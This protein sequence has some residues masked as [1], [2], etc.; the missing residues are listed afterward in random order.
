MEVKDILQRIDPIGQRIGRGGEG[1]Q[2]A[3]HAREDPSHT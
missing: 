3:N 1:R 2:H